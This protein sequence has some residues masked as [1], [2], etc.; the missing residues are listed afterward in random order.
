MITMLAV[1]L[2][3]FGGV[4]TLL[5]VLY[6]LACRRTYSI[7]GKHVLI[8]GGSSGIGKALAC[9]AIR[10]G[11]A[12]V[13]LLARNEDRLAS[14]KAEL[15]QLIAEGSS[16]RVHIISADVSEAAA[17]KEKILTSVASSGHVDVLINCAGITHTA[18][19]QETPSEKYQELLHVNVLGCVHPTQALLPSMMEKKSGK[20]VFISSQ[21]GQ[22]GLYGY[23]AYSITKYGLRGLAEVLH[24]ELRPHNIGV[25]ISF[26]PDTDTPQL[27]A[28]VPQRSEI[29]RKLADFGAVFKADG[30]AKD[31][32]KGVERGSFQITHGF[33]GFLLGVLNAGMGP[34]NHTWDAV[35]Q[36]LLM[37]VFRVVSLVYRALFDGVVRKG[38]RNAK[39][40]Q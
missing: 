7:R 25:S 12:A 24:M 33:D 31:I 8:T 34:V 4:S 29:Q 9:E 30:V 39:K 17:V 35:V 5:L 19:M 32:W 2:Y 26:P 21:A 22:L 18:T 6:L 23:S 15:E 14:T 3:L 27:Q 13:S 20:I 11:A 1:L 36:V 28:E 37:G 40:A 38:L 16:Q 10:K